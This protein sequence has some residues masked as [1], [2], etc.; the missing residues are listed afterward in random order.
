MQYKNIENNHCC[1]QVVVDGGEGEE[2]WN[3]Y[4]LRYNYSGN[5]YVGTTIDFNDRML[6]H[7][8]KESEKKNLPNW[9]PKNKSKKGFKFYWF[10][11]E[12]EGVEQGEAE[13]CEN[14]LA[15]LLVKEIEKINHESPIREI[16]VGSGLGIDCKG[17]NQKVDPTP[18][19]DEAIEKYLIKLKE[20]EWKDEKFQIE[21][22]AIGY[23]GEY[24]NSQCK[25]SWEEVASIRH[26]SNNK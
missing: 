9:S 12:K 22:C 11:I 10:Y 19:L 15:N 26:L 24:D 16:H 17:Y 20:L 13:Y 3:L 18:S 4:V 6:D 23:V 7:W 2:K 1:E 14:R 21:C 5:Y 8:R 25:K